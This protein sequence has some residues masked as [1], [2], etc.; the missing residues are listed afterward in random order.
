MILFQSYLLDIIM[1]QTNFVTDYKNLKVKHPNI[2][3]R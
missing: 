1:K 3:P 2:I